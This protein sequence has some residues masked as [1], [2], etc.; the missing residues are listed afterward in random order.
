[1]MQH[2][3]L[4]VLLLSCNPACRRN[5][6]TEDDRAMTASPSAVFT[7]CAYFLAIA[8]SLTL[9]VPTRAETLSG[10][11]L[12]AALRQGGYVIVMRHPSSPFTIPDKTHGDP[13]NTRLERQLDDTGRKTA[14][15]MGEAFRSLHI[16]VGDVL[17]SPAYRAREAVRLAA[18]GEPQIVEELDDGGH[19]MQANADDRR[20]S[21]LRRKAAEPPRKGKNTLI[22]THTPNLTGAFGTAAAGIAAGEALIFHPNGTAEP[23][24]V[25]RVRIEEWPKLASSPQSER[26]GEGSR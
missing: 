25:A 3:S 5:H 23:D 15:A 11:A 24:L 6:A 9:A 12:V 7:R 8:I 2:L 22:V 17:S 20:S 26:H 14:K 19:S 4:W 10:T 1:M 18:F 13:G 21:W 16:P